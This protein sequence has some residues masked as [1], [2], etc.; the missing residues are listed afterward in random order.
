[1]LK[2]ENF[3]TKAQETLNLA[4]SYANEANHTQIE[5]EHLFWVC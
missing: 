3:T 1:M 5:P 4:A 2:P